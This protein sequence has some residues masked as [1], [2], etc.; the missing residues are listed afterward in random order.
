MGGLILSAYLVGGL[1]LASPPKLDIKV[2]SGIQVPVPVPMTVWRG[3][4][5]K[6]RPPSGR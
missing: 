1:Q 6:L 5:V 3:V 4:P 2:V